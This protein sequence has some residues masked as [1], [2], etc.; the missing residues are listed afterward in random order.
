MAKILVVNNDIDTMLLLKSWFERKKYKVKFT[1]NANDVP[2]II[3]EFAPDILLIDILQ[4]KVTEQLKSQYKTKKIP[5]IVMTGYTLDTQNE[6]P[7]MVDDVIEKPFD[8]KLL[9]KKIENALQKTG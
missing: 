6:S 5:V 3:N 4:N 1:G 9:E 2:H 7:V 8:P